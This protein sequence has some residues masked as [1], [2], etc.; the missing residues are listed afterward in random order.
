M[1]KF[2]FKEKILTRKKKIPADHMRAVTTFRERLL[3]VQNERNVSQLT[4]ISYDPSDILAYATFD[5]H[6]IPFKYNHAFWISPA[7]LYKLF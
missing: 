4:K 6:H 1:L 7:I 5:E 3:Y 2:D